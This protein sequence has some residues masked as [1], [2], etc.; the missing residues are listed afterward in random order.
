MSSVD[1]KKT[2]EGVMS[3]NNPIIKCYNSYGNPDSFVEG[4]NA[5]VYEIA[6]SYR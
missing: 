1:D 4:T 6:I 3:S 5:K 2:Y